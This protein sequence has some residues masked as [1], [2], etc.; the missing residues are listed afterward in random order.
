MLLQI[1]EDLDSPIYRQIVDQIKAQVA[2]GT[3]EKGD[4][5]PS[6]REL[7]KDLKINVNTIYKSYK[8]LETQGII[9]MRVGFGVTVIA[10]RQDRLKRSDREKIIRELLE[11]LQVEA[12]HLGFDDNYL[13]EHLK[14][15]SKEQ[16]K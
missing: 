9:R 7:A 2:D 14:K 16:I 11:H 6:V 5:L 10:E 3:L 8:E 13:I 12:Y 4:R 15:R 1:R